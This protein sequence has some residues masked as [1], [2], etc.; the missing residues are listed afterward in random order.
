MKKSS[1]PTSV[2]LPKQRIERGED[3]GTPDLHARVEYDLQGGTALFSGQMMIR[4]QPSEDVFHVDHRVVHQR[5]DGDGHAAQ[6]HRIDGRT[7]P[8]Q[9]EHRGHEGQGYRRERDERG[10]EVRKE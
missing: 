9:G 2:H 3:D 1:A 4:A 10:P 5:P 7:E 6:G 8:F